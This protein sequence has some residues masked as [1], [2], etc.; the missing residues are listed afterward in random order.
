MTAPWGRALSSVK[1]KTGPHAAAY[2]L[3]A[4]SR[5]PSQNRVIV[6]EPRLMICRSLLYSNEI[7]AHTM[8][9]PSWNASYSVI[10]WDRLCVPACL[11]TLTRLTSGCRTNFNTS[12]N[13][14]LP[15]SD[16]VKMISC[17]HHFNHALLDWTDRRTQN[18]D[19]WRYSPF[20]CNLERT[21]WKI[22]YYQ[23]T[24][25]PQMSLEWRSLFVSASLQ[26]QYI[27]HPRCRIILGK[28]TIGFRTNVC[29][30]RD[31]A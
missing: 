26:Q 5:T 21:V 15:Q 1:T 28:E 22:S 7:P 8:M 23:W 2:N 3:I 12:V 30:V 13:I 20:I 11:Q 24:L 25:Q 27:D 29:L 18:R 19:T 10:Y 16:M 4:G 6:R 14:T 31:I 9:L 17:R